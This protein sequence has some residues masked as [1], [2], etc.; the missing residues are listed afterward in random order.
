MSRC[1][2]KN[3][4]R[5]SCD[6]RD[7]WILTRVAW[8][9]LEQPAKDYIPFYNGFWKRHQLI[10]AAI[11]AVIVQKKTNE[12]VR[13]ILTEVADPDDPV[14]QARSWKKAEVRS[15]VRV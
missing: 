10:H 4:D 12:T 14:L 15:L 1:P 3:D 8:Y 13:S 9:K 2:L 6:H 7:V 11:Y 5:L